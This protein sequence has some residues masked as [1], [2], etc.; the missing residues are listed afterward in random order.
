MK[1]TRRAA[2]AT[3]T[4]TLL[5]S[6]QVVHTLRIILDAEEGRP[7][8]PISASLA[9]AS[10]EAQGGEGCIPDLFAAYAEELAAA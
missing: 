10:L 3:E 9:I 6:D 1:T 5:D 8:G 4:T 2:L 7:A